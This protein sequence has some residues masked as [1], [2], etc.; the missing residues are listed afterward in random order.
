MVQELKEFPK[1]QVDVLVN[2]FMMGFLDDK[3][4]ITPGVAGQLKM[5]SRWTPGFIF[6]QLN[7]NI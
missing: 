2:K 3:F 4:E 7:K 1:M 6:K 5:M